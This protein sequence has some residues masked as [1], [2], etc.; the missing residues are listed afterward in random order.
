MRARSA[1]F[2][3]ALA[4]SSARLDFT[5]SA[6]RSA[7]EVDG[8][9]AAGREGTGGGGGAAAAG[10]GGG[11]AAAAGGGGGAAARS[12]FGIGGG[13]AAAGGGGAGAD[14]GNGGGGA[15]AAGTGVGGGKGA[16]SGR[17]PEQMPHA[18]SLAGLFPNEQM[19]QAHVGAPEDE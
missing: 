1:A 15:A 10:T 11:G 18:P 12:A 2:F 3:A 16:A 19:P 17:G 14:G 4:S 6:L 5:K 9:G 8:K 7:A 13:A